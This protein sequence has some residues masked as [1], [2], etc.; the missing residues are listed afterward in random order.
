MMRRSAL[1]GAVAVA[2]SCTTFEDP[3]IVRDLRVLAMSATPPE[4]MIDV[5]MQNL[6][7]PSDLLGQLAATTVCALVADPDHDRQLRWS[8]TVCSTGDDARCDPER[9]QYELG[10]GVIEDP[11]DAATVQLPCAE[12]LPD[13][14]LLSVLFD[15]FENDPV[16]GLGGLDYTVMLRI[17]GLEGADD[18]DVFAAKHV[19]VSPRIPANREAN[20]NPS[21]NGVDGSVS[22]LTLDVPDLRCNSLGN[23]PIVD[24]GALVTLYPLE[25]DDVREPYVVP[26]LDGTTAMLRETITYWWYASRGSFTDET[27]GGP[28]DLLGNQALLGT[29]WRAPTRDN[30]TGATY[31]SIWIVQRDE[32]LGVSWYQTCMLVQR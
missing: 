13:N 23:A 21:L 24:A 19:R 31:V 16:H 26:T 4:Q 9:P 29:Q 6:P 10:S 14:R 5:D 17:G 18:D 11:E 27:T 20:R 28:H 1:A 30:L 32:R 15:V 12:L 22:T 7:T 8:M 2:A 3:Q 25:P